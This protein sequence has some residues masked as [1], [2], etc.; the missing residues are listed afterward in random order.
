MDPRVAEKLARHASQGKMTPNIGG[1]PDHSRVQQKLAAHS[2]AQNK[3]A[4]APEVK[5]EEPEAEAKAA[6][7]RQTGKGRHS[8]A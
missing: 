2:A 5:A 6:P 1:T 3:P 4:A 8:G 7:D